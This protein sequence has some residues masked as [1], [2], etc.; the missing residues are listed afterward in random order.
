MNKRY[1][2]LILKYR[3]I[4][5]IISNQI[6][7]CIELRIQ[8]YLVPDK[9]LILRF[10]SKIINK[11]LITPLQLSAGGNDKGREGNGRK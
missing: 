9:L 6:F 11:L 1:L 2:I 8:N 3:N 7:I 4:T 10:L 5:L